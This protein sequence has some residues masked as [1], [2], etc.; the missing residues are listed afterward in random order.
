MMAVYS[1]FIARVRVGSEEN[2]RQRCLDY[3]K[4]TADNM[5]QDCYV[6]RYEEQRRIRGEWTKQEKVLFPGY[7]FIVVDLSENAKK[8][9]LSDTVEIEQMPGNMKPEKLKEMEQ[10]ICRIKGVIELLKRD[11]K[12]AVLNEEEVQLLRMFDDRGQ[13]VEMSEGVI[14]RS[15]IK[16]YSGPLVGKEKY[17][18]KIDRHKRRA[19]LEMPIFGE[20]KRVQVG[21]EI[22]SKN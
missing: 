17:I 14:E 13:R 7:V 6:F 20:T 12:P 3:L 4:L 5:I 8:K 18:R 21:L 11:G 22:V 15:K 9:R 19:F 16:V 10:E 1:W 2:V